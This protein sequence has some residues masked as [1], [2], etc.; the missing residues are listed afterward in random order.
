MTTN[1]S[2]SEN[3]SGS[4]K[5]YAFPARGRFAIGGQREGAMLAANLQMPRGVKVASGSGW[6][7]EEAIQAERSRDI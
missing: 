2:G 1:V 3:N 5:I 7:H 4:A 6:Y